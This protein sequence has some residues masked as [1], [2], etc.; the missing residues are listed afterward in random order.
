M[1][2][3]SFRTALMAIGAVVLLAGPA[4]ANNMLV[5]PSFAT[6]N[7]MG[8]H[9]Y[10]TWSI[11]KRSG[12]VHSSKYAAVNSLTVDSGI[13]K[14]RWAGIYQNVSVSSIG[15]QVFNAS[16]WISTAATGG[17]EK[18]FLQIQ[19]QNLSGHVLAQY[20]TV[21]STAPQTYKQVR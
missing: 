7:F 6:N 19:F 20:D 21:S 16:V 8:W 2:K 14:T 4:A 3:F 11:R 5:N 13:T 9:T 17:Y 1:L 15:G 18:A 12:D 10:G